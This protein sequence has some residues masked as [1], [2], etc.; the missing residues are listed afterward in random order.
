[1]GSWG[2]GDMGTWGHGHYITANRHS[3]HST[4]KVTGHKSAHAI[5]LLLHKLLAVSIHAWVIT[6]GCVYTCMGHHCW[7]CLYM[8]GSSLLAVSIHAW[9]ITVGCVYTCMGHHCWLCL[10]MHGLSLL[11]V[12][13]HAWV[14]TAG[15]EIWR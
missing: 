3:L 5:L 9:V 1:M 6:V 7:L 8:H 4:A 14:I 13:I 15:C 11:A 2:H 10:C 12:S